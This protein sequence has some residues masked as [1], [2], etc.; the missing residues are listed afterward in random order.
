MPLLNLCEPSLSAANERA[1]CLREQM[2][3]A[4]ED[5]SAIPRKTPADRPAKERMK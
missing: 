2:T 5:K 1:L 4:L 3:D